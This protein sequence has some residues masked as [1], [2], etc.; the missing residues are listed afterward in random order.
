MLL[1]CG[2]FFHSRYWKKKLNILGKMQRAAIRA[3]MMGSGVMGEPSND[4]LVQGNALRTSHKC[5]ARGQVINICFL[6]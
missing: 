1:I 5:T 3:E 6:A 2:A 4:S